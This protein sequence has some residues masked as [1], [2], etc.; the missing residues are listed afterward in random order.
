MG[1]ALNIYNY[2]KLLQ[3]GED[4]VI[5][6]GLLMVI[7]CHKDSGDIYRQVPAGYVNFY[8]RRV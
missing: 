6:S 4:H 7:G 2:L 1:E 8:L 5:S 3:G